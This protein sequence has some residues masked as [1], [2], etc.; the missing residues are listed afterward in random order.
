MTAFLSEPSVICAA[1]SSAGEFFRSVS[2]GKSSGIVRT[3]CFGR[4]FWA[5]LV[6]AEL[7]HSGDPFDSRCLRLLAESLRQIA[8]AVEMAKSR[9]GA[10]RVGV[11]VGSCD[12]GSERSLAAHRA[13]FADGSFPPSY[14]LREQ[15]AEYVADFAA[16]RLGVSG[17]AMAFSTACSSSAS[18]LA[19]A[20]DL[21][22]SG[23]L[24]AVVAGGVDVASPTVLL[25]FSALGAVSEEITNPMS[26]NRRGITLG[27]GAAFF[28][29]G[30]EDIGG[31]G[32]ALLGAGESSD[33]AHMTAPKAD[34]S[35]A[36]EAM[37]RALLDAGLSPREIGYVNLHATGTELNDAMEARAVADVLGAGVPASGTKPL[38]GHTL[39]A[40]G[41]VE[42][43][44]CFLAVRGGRLPVHVWDG[45][46]DGSIPALNI[47]D[48]PAE[49]EVGAAMSNSFAFGGCNVSLVVGRADFGRRNGEFD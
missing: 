40:A 10:S 6:G 19:A 38:T 13:F 15:G 44:A 26:A 31:T 36:A 35:G 23:A 28:L 42:L 22:R 17:A 11:C 33:A 27:E 49:A 21:V 16:R 37:R 48:G 4:E 8:P 2:S 30:R 20:R 32:I 12:N 24:D 25:G 43:A 41:A 1:G 18:A 3:E 5:G 34:G 7:P 9:Y 14:S 46:R 45:A 39:G 29:V 47:V